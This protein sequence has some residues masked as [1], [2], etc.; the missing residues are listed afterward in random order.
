MMK[1]FYIDRQSVQTEQ[2][3]ASS[4]YFF[5]LTIINN[6]IGTPHAIGSVNEYQSFVCSLNQS[7]IHQKKKKNQN[8]FSKSKKKQKLIGK[9]FYLF[10]RLTN[11]TKHPPVDIY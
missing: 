7:E 9:K 6:L 2:Q 1:L 8:K 10:I 5:S 11:T 4:I 3:M